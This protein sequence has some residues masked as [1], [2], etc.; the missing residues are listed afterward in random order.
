MKL[1]TL[2]FQLQEFH[3]VN[4]NL[5]VR[6]GYVKNDQDTKYLE[7]EELSYVGLGYDGKISLFGEGIE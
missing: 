4:G 1:E 3:K 6:I 5:D 7:Y 2:I